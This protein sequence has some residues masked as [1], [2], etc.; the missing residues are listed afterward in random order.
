MDRIQAHRLLAVNSP[1]G[2]DV[3][4]LR[5]FTGREELA[6]LFEYELDLLSE[7]DDLDTDALLGAPIS[8]RVSDGSGHDRFFNGIVSEIQQEPSED[9][10]DTRLAV[11]RATVVPWFW[12]LTRTQRLPHLSTQKSVARHY[13]ADVFNAVRVFKRYRS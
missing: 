9:I 6:R 5:R 11:Y 12:L 2:E 8:V 10:N 13:Q 4:L 3:L 1:L 7:R